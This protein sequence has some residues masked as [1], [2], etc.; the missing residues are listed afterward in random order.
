MTIYRLRDYKRMPWKNGGGET[1]EIAVFPSDASVGDFDWRISM[2]TVTT[3]GPFS[4][5]P[6]IDR[7]ITIIDGDAIELSVEGQPPVLL[8]QAAEPFSFPGDAPTSG[9][10]RDGPIADLNVMVRRGLLHSVRRMDVGDVPQTATT[11]ATLF[12]VALDDI[13]LR[14]GDEKIALGRHDTLDLSG[15]TPSDVAGEASGAIL[16]IAIG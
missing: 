14:I 6:Q 15:S 13:T 4:R 2:A 5:F 12:I 1:L 7:I 9:R 8:D 10:L 11:A 16:L 3:D